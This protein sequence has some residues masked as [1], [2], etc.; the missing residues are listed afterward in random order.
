MAKLN[1][2]DV[3]GV[4]A[5]GGDALNVVARGETIRLGLGHTKDRDDV[6]RLLRH[7]TVDRATPHDKAFGYPEFEEHFAEDNAKFVR[8]PG[9]PAVGHLLVSQHRVLFFK[10]AP[11]EHAEVPLDVVSLTGARL[12][13]AG[14]DVILTSATGESATI[15]V[16]KP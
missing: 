15:S 5:A 10:V 13:D 3:T 11:Q 14:N 7:V 4:S 6:G 16:S 1:F 9:R 2:R 8:G 12:K